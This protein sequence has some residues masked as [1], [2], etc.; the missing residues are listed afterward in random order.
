MPIIE[1]INHS[2]SHQSWGM[3][4]IDIHIEGRFEGEV[5]ARYSVSDPL[6]R[7]IQYGFNCREPMRFWA[8]GDEA[9][10]V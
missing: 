1:L 8:M 6:I 3:S 2:P 5:F 4:D 7:L 10:G 9:V